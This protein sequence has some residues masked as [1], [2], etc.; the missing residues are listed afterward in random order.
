MKFQMWGAAYAMPFTFGAMYQKYT[1]SD[2]I[3]T[4]PFL[5]VVML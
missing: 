3:P 5:S 4:V 1:S 2:P